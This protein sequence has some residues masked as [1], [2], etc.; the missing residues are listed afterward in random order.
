M[1]FFSFP[2]D[3]QWNPQTEAVE[4]S[5]TIGGYEGT[6][7]APARVLRRLLGV[8]TTPE[9]YLETYYLHRTQFEQAAEVKLRRRELAEDGN[10]ELSGRDLRRLGQGEKLW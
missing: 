2:E 8:P 6:V 10:V 1:A 4:F 7:R 9:K 5:V 3:A